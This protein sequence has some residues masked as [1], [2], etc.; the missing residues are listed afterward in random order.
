MPPV[1]R[2]PAPRRSSALRDA[3]QLR[4][5]IR[6][7]GASLGRVIGRLEGRPTF[8][9]VELPAKNWRRPGGRATLLGGAQTRGGGGGP[10]PTAA[11][12]QAM[13][14]TLYFELV[15]LAEENFRI[16]LLRRRRLA[17]LRGEAGA[18][19][20]RESIEA[21]VLELK[22]R[23]MPP[24]AMQSL[25]DRLNIELVFTAHPTES[26]RRTL[27]GKLRRLGGILRE[28]AEPGGAAAA[29]GGDA[30]AVE[31]E[32]ASLWLTD[33]SRTERPE[34]TD[35]ARTGL[36]YFD[37]TLFDTLP[38]LYADLG[39]VL[40][41]HYPGVRAPARWLSFGSWIGGDRAAIPTSPPR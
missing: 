23:G 12:D 20:M 4:A 18:Q 16:L 29:G 11:F 6:A 38:R 5:E 41:R 15:N 3:G 24:A 36:W 9:R 30:E 32:I 2:P 33:R 19:P 31:R 35:E 40:A 34:V 27:L 28:R 39:R 10:A 17:R 25:V 37:T 26:K 7:L 22:G 1:S 21:A 14:F 13:A 8:D